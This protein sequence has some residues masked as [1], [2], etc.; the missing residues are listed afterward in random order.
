MQRPALSLCVS[1][2]LPLSLST[3]PLRDSSLFEYSPTEKYRPI[4]SVPL[5]PFSVSG[6]FPLLLP[7]PVAVVLTDSLLVDE[8]EVAQY[9]KPQLWTKASQCWSRRRER[10]PE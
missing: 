4:G 7:S 8:L 5:P 6:T 10:S 9:S 1:L 2:S 3:K